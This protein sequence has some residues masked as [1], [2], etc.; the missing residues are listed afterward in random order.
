MEEQKMEAEN[1]KEEKK[2]A[3]CCQG[4]K[5]H[6]CC[7]HKVIFLVIA[8]LIIFSLGVCFGLCREGGHRGFKQR[9]FNLAQFEGRE[10]MNRVDQEKQG[11][12]PMQKQN[13]DGSKECGCQGQGQ[14]AA[15]ATPSAAVKSVAPV[16]PVK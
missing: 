5:H 16:T 2:E 6:K 13:T 8:S 7:G 3:G 11:G 14:A 4:K 15:S 1:I 10:M 12:C 9:D